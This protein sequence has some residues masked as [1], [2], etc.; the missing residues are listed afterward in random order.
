[1]SLIL[2]ILCIASVV[3]YHRQKQLQD[4]YTDRS[5]QFAELREQQ[6]GVLDLRDFNHPFYEYE[7][8][9][10]CLRSPI[11][12]NLEFVL[13]PL[14]ES[15]KQ[16]LASGALQGIHWPANSAWGLLGLDRT[17][18]DALVESPIGKWLQAITF[19]HAKKQ[20]GQSTKPAPYAV[21]A[22]RLRGGVLSVFFAKEYSWEELG[23]FREQRQQL[24]S[25][26]LSSDYTSQGNLHNPLS[27]SLWFWYLVLLA[28]LLCW[29]YQ[30]SPVSPFWV[31]PTQWWWLILPLVMVWIGSKPILRFFDRYQLSPTV[32]AHGLFRLMAPW[33]LLWFWLL[34]HE[35]NIAFSPAETYTQQ[36]YV[37]TVNSEGRN[38]PWFAE[39]LPKQGHGNQ[40]LPINQTLY[41][42]LQGGEIVEIQ[43]RQGAFSQPWICRIEIERSLYYQFPW[44]KCREHLPHAKQA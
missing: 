5:I 44:K 42:Q 41:Q 16:M 20:R 26:L 33:W 3:W 37:L 29:N 27:Q 34:S 12:V 1:M 24:K 2:I 28:G 35:Y 8:G 18:A 6:P 36:W 17:T 39:L 9:C 31:L 4:R 7:Q 11:A 40:R 10:S 43:Y 23:K 13:L 25:A 21:K 22:I 32:S 15:H 19:P 14:E 38:G 30:I